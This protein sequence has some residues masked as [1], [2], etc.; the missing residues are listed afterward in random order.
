MFQACLTGDVEAIKNTY[1]ELQHPEQVPFLPALATLAV[2]R[3]QA[4]VLEFC[5]EKGVVADQ[6]LSAAVKM[7]HDV[8]I[9]EVLYAANWKQMQESPR[10]LE[11]MAR[12]LIQRKG[13]SEE[14]EW[15]LDRGAVIRG[16]TVQK[17]AS[18]SYRPPA[19]LMQKLLQV[20]SEA[21]RNPEALAYAASRGFADIVQ[22][23]LEGGLAADATSSSVHLMDLARDGPGKTALFHAVS[24]DNGDLKITDDHIET[25]KI[26]LDNGANPNMT[27]GYNLET[28]LS[29]ALNFRKNKRAMT[30]LLLS[31]PDN[32]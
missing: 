12:E 27:C 26:L 3:K 5:F 30:K 31:Y 17:V 29:V 2:Q 22:H 6:Y 20:D 10:V 9:F 15:F 25:A 21:A 18:F 28:P 32:L 16:A 23:M 19:T 8:G 14:L 4:R 13:T 11:S 24:G 1:E 7:N